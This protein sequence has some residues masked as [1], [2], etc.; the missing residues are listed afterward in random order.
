M[1]AYFA[2]EPMGKS[3]RECSR[4]YARECLLNGSIVVRIDHPD[5][6]VEYIAGTRYDLSPLRWEVRPADGVIEV[7]STGFVVREIPGGVSIRRATSADL[8]REDGPSV[9]LD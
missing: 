2:T 4:S 3:V 7:I 6:T 9:Q 1:I 5:S 8:A